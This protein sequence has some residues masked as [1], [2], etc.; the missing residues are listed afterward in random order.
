MD[1][2]EHLVLKCKENNL[3]VMGKDKTDDWVPSLENVEVVEIWQRWVG[4]SYW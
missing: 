1:E 3:L 4:G 2:S